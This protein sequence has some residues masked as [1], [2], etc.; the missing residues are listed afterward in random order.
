MVEPHGKMKDLI[1]Q[2][3]IHFHHSHEG[4]NESTAYQ[5]REMNRNYD[6]NG[7]YRIPNQRRL[8]SYNNNKNQQNRN[9]KSNNN[10]G[11][12]K[13]RYQGNQGSYNNYNNYGSRNTNNNTQNYN[14]QTNSSNI[15]FTYC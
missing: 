11:Q 8:I 14:R 12:G 5:A 7:R 2:L 1:S 6:N 4:R 10:N 13:Y 15:S 3:K 9:Y